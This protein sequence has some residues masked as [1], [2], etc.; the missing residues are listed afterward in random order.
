MLVVPKEQTLSTELDLEKAGLDEL[1]EV[2]IIDHGTEGA[3]GDRMRVLWSFVEKALSKDPHLENPALLEATEALINPNGVPAV[4]PLAVG[5]LWY[6]LLPG[7]EGGH[8]P[9]SQIGSVLQ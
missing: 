2:L 1:N 5:E 4:W 8:L 6:C 7:F 3:T 9:G